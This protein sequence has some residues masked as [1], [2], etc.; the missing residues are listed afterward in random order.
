M[1]KAEAARDGFLLGTREAHERYVIGPSKAGRPR[2]LKGCLD[3]R[4]PVWPWPSGGPSRFPR[5]GIE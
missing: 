5:R 2:I 4:R 3:A 1:S